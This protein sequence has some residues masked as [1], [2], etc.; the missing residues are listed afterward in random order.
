MTKVTRVGVVGAGTMGAAIAQHFCMKGLEVVLMDLDEARVAKG[1]AAIEVALSD[2]MAK[3]LISEV[4]LVRMLGA[5]SSVTS[6]AGLS[7]CQLVVEAVFEDLEVKRALFA[8]L[9]AHVGPDCILA[10]NTSSLLVT[11]I[12]QALR[13]PERFVGVHYF[14]HAA[15]NKLVELIAGARTSPAV[16]DALEAF[17]AGC[18]KLPIRAKDAPGFV[19][20]RFFVPWL[21]EA[22]RLHEEGKGS[23]AFIDEVAR[24]VFGVGLGPFALMNATGVP[25]AQ[26][27]AQGLADKLGAFYAPAEALK[28]QVAS[29]QDWNVADTTVPAGGAND[30]AEVTERLLAASLGVAAQL[31]AEGV[32]DVT[33]TDLGARVGLRWPKGP[34]ELARERG[35]DATRALV[36]KWF[37]KWGLPVPAISLDFSWV[38]SQRVGRCGFVTFNVPD[39]MNPLNEDTV[40]QLGR[41]LDELE[42]D[43]GIDTIVVGGRGKAFVAGAD[44]KLFVDA[45][46]KG[47]LK[48]IHRFTQRGQAVLARLSGSKKKTVAFLNGLTLGGGL[49]L[50]LACQHRVAT[51]RATLAFPETGIGIYP[52]LGG[53]QRTPRLVG[54]GLAKYLIATGQFVDAPTA[55]AWG[56]VDQVVEPTWDLPAIAG[57]ATQVNHSARSATPPAADAFTDFDGVLSDA[58]LARPGVKPSE[59]ALRRKAPRA[60]AMAMRLIDEGERRPLDEGLRLE[61]ASL[62]EIFGT[63]DARVGL[64]SLLDKTR[65]EFT[66]R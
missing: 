17:Y 1:R 27:A 38:D 54:K 23:I 16:V 10:T 46:D 29:K 6:P 43:A 44:V 40:E 57:L 35:V 33:A 41:R 65:P 19:V 36:T 51:T 61:L 22:V 15:K 47:D 62:E 2:A 14:Y 60:L 39:R 30:E 49:E 28:R 24:R 52:G 25:I 55:Y 3:K 58:V 7:G 37:T 59:K 13:Q 50:A 31:V 4:E 34:F 18:D 8:T 64:G 21:N 56:L 32:A 11:E 48:R 45:M 26:H 66:G 53:T 9:E 63:R 42:R 5:M 12:A 20:N